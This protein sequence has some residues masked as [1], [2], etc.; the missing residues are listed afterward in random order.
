MKYDFETLVDRS[1]CGSEKW[2][3]MWIKSPELA[4]GVVPFSVADME[5]KNAPEIIEGLKRY[6][7][8]HILGYTF[9]T[10]EYFDAVRGWMKKRHSW[11]VEKEWIVHSP[12]VVPALFMLV[13]ALCEPGDGVIVMPPVYYPFFRAV[14]MNGCK[15]ASCPL[16]YENGGYAINYALLETLCRDQNNKMLIF[17]SPHNPV[18]RVW[19]KEE[20]RK[21]GEICVKNGVKIVSDEIHFDLVMPGH[22]HTVFSQAGDF[23][24]EVILCTAPSKTFNLATMQTSNIV[25]QKKEYRDRFLA[26]KEK[27]C[28]E[29]MNAL[30]F[31]A[32]RLAYTEGEAWMEEMLQVVHGNYRFAVEFLNARLPQIRPVEMQGTYLLWL[33]CTALGKTAA[34]LEDMMVNKARLFLDEGYIFGEGGEGFERVNL[35][36]PQWVLRE[37]L[38]RLEKAVNQL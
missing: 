23:G 20:L 38:E 9:P 11:E 28:V 32:C 33:D 27:Y 36:C 6:L 24:E 10:D 8:S 2:N 16:V 4:E 26:V 31:E 15:T 35:A 25:I 34:E 7:D 5:L 1:H 30:G 12:G 18:G 22:T 13:A 29:S 14:E 19:T 21:V 3:D 37:G 17:C